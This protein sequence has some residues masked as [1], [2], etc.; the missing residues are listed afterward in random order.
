MR[1]L[2]VATD[3]VACGRRAPQAAGRDHSVRPACVGRSEPSRPGSVCSAQ[4][5]TGR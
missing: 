4:W 5:Q 3:L 2:D 1:R